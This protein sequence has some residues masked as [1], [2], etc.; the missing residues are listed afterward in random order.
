MIEDKLQS[1][2]EEGTIMIDSQGAVVGQANALSVYDLGDYS[3]G[4]P[5]RVTARVGA[6]RGKIVD[7]QR[8]SEMGGRIH[9]KGVMIITGYL[10][11]KYAAKMPIAMFATMT[12]EQLYEEVEGDSA[13]S[14]ELYVLLSALSGLPLKQGIGVTGSIN[15]HGDIQP[16]G[17]VN[18]KIEGFFEVCRAG[19]LTGD[20]G[21]IIPRRNV[22]HLMLKREVVDAIAEDK[23]SIWA[24]ENVDEGIEI[25]TG[26]EAGEELP[27]GD[28]PEG[29]VHYIVTQ[30]LR[31]LAETAREFGMPQIPAAVGQTEP[32]ASVESTGRTGS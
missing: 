11:G 32:A 27:E 28:Y 10:E 1:L 9:S 19:G 2:I 21:V 17:G 26:V 5:S 30:R 4:R 8:E 12:F 29:S 6:G 23:F 14:T 15:Q 25:L 18:R 31:T 7:I 20:Q 16:I 22:R 13:S 24:I 3:F